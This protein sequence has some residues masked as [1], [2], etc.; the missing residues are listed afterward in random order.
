VTVRPRKEQVGAFAAVALLF[1]LIS[2]AGA[3]GAS[4]GALQAKVESARGRASAL[5][6]ELQEAQRELAAAQ[7]QA[8]AASE[9]ERQLGGLLANGQ[10]RSAELA[11]KIDRSEHR[12]SVQRRRLGRA[13]GALAQRLVSIYESGSPS[14]ASVILDSTDYEDL[15]TRTDYLARIEESDTALAQR[16]AQVRGEIHHQLE[17]VASLKGRVDA[18]NARLAAARSQISAVRGNAEA[19]VAQL[20]SVSAARSA[21]LASLKTE[22]GSWVSDIQAAKAAAAERI[23]R[24]VAEEEVGRWLGG[25]YSIPTEIVM[26]ESGGDYGA[27]NPSSGAG[28]AYQILPS[29]WQAYGGKGLPQDAPKAEQDSIAAQIWAASGPGAWVCA[30]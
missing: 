23:S 30:G 3:S 2:V 13:R 12:L 24:E 22:I 29:T 6:G 9:R 11:G 7:S 26:C 8:T 25:P 15:A 14:E 5:A 10:Q 4:I 17:A 28:G 19:A 20:Q 27:V 16:V 18:H 21:S 1:A